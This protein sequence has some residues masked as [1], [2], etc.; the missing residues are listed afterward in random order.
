MRLDLNGLAFQAAVCWEKN[1]EGK[2]SE[3][4][5]LSRVN[6]ERMLWVELHPEALRI[7]LQ[8]DP[9]KWLVL[10]FRDSAAFAEAQQ[11]IGAP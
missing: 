11:R 9:D 3:V 8:L 10:N 5:G 1:P 7:S 6:L 4:E 2:G